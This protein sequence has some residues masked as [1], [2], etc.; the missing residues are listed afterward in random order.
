[1]V[2]WCAVC[3]LGCN[4][5]RPAPACEGT[6]TKKAPPEKSGEGAALEEEE[7]VEGIW[8]PTRGGGGGD[9]L[10]LQSRVSD[11]GW[12]QRRRRRSLESCGHQPER[13]PALPR[14]KTPEL[15]EEEEEEREGNEE[16][17]TPAADMGS[18]EGFIA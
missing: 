12:R 14:T 15:K 2:P 16:I 1:M 18:G 3:E 9:S 13:Y 4:W 5:A 8:R 7:E 6:D 17:P 11:G 10:V